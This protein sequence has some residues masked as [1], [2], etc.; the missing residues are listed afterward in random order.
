M[1]NEA[2]RRSRASTTTHF[3]PI[4]IEGEL[5]PAA[6]DNLLGVDYLRLGDI[7]LNIY[8][9]LEY[10]MFPDERQELEE[11]VMRRI[12]TSIS[13]LGSCQSD[14]RQ[15]KAKSPRAFLS[16]CA[17]AIQ[18]LPIL[19]Y[20]YFEALVEFILCHQACA[21]SAFF[22]ERDELYNANYKTLAYDLCPTLADNFDLAKFAP[23]PDQLM[24]YVNARPDWK[25]DSTQMVEYLADRLAFLVCARLIPDAVDLDL[26]KIEWRFDRVTEIMGPLV[27]HLIHRLL[28]TFHRSQ[29]AY[30]FYDQ[31][32][33]MQAWNY[34]NQNGIAVTF[35]GIIPKG[36]VGINPAFPL[37]WKFY[38]GRYENGAVEKLMWLN[39]AVQPKLVDKKYTFM[40][41][42]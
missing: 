14:L 32:K 29:L 27:G 20:F 15:A 36:E 37:A 22:H 19:G 6:R 23:S 4:I 42:K 7:Q 3:V 25:L 13:F 26:R 12:R 39:L 34:W 40:R 8:R 10:L 24:A 17:D 28:R 18:L 11:D 21:R 9:T 38:R 35:N 2:P 5:P 41:S 31:S 33:A 30:F 16:A 1:E